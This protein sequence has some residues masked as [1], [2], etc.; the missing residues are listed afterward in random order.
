MKKIKHHDYLIVLIVAFFIY[1]VYAESADIENEINSKEMEKRNPEASTDDQTITTTLDTLRDS[2][3]LQ[4]NQ[5][6]EWKKFSKEVKT[7]KN[8]DLTY[9]QHDLADK[10]TYQRISEISIS[11][12]EQIIRAKYYEQRV[13]DFYNQL[14]SDQKTIFDLMFN[15]YANKD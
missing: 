4:A 2:L 12:D 10:D 14:N 9:N 8:L 5:K 7:F 1:P 3:D 15:P 6:K 11:R 13:L